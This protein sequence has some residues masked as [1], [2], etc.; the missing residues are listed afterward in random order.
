VWLGKGKTSTTLAKVLDHDLVAEPEAPTIEPPPVEELPSP[1]E[2]SSPP[3]S[4]LAA[5]AAKEE[6]PVIPEAASGEVTFTFGDRRYRVR[7]L[8]KNLSHG[9]LK[10]NLLAAR[11]EGLHVDTLDLYSSRQRGAF[12]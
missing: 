7:G 10:V 12:I 11:G 4:L 5:I 3:L 9:Q 8:D 6:T 2:T 1:A